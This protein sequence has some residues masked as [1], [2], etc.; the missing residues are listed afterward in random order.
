MQVLNTSIRSNM[1]QIK[2]KS[3]QK[4]S[5]MSM[6]SNI[7]QIHIELTQNESEKKFA[8]NEVIFFYS[9]LLEL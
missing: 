4:N 2:M 9:L 1:S 6:M 3:A 8:Q 7:S 5:A